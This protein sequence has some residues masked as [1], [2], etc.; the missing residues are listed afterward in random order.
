MEFEVI[1]TKKKLFNTNVRELGIEMS[2][3]VKFVWRQPYP[4]SGQIIR[5]LGGITEDNL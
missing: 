1:E 5:V 3:Y 4:G 2:I